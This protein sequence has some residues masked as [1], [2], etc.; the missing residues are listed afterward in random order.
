ME[1]HTYECHGCLSLNGNRGGW[2][3]KKREALFEFIENMLNV[4]LESIA[5][6]V[7]QLL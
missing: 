6:V 3:L 4:I 1:T 7:E 5:A 2:V